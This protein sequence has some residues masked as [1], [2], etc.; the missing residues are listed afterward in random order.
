MENLVLIDG[1]SMINRAFYG[2]MNGK[3]MMTED[4]TYTNAI[5]GFLSISSV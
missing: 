5:Y 2:T 3:F 1:N 4:G